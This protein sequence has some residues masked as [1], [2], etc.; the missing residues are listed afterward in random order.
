M[1]DGFV[2]RSF[3]MP[4]Q[5]IEPAGMWETV[6]ECWRR[7][8]DLANWCVHE[9]AKND[10]TRTPDMTKLPAMP[11]INGVKLKGLYGKASEFFGFTKEGSWWDGACVCA[12]TICRDVET[13]YKA[14]RLELI[15]HR[16]RA[17]RFYR[18]PY[19]WPIHSNRWVSARFDQN[20]RPCVE[21]ILP[22]RELAFADGGTGIRLRGGK[23]FARQMGLFRQVVSR[24]LPRL[25]CVLREHK[26]LGTSSRP[27]E[28]GGS[29][30]MLKMVAKLPVKE[31]KDG[32]VMTLFTDKEAFWV[33]SL[34]G[35]RED[36]QWTANYD[37]VRRMYDWLGV[38][39]ARRQRLSQDAKMES[40]CSSSKRRQ[41]QRSL[42]N[43]CEKQKRRMSSWLHEATAHV[44]GYCV[45]QG[46]SEVIYDSSQRFS[47]G[48]PWFRL[49]SMLSDKLKAEGIQ[50]HEAALNEDLVT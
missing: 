35:K 1:S 44:V 13:S 46:V 32:K 27:D 26:H 34:S 5:V 15:W 37:H 25:Q 4:V 21:V 14:D 2:V 17:L 47:D 50:L 31:K 7:G 8:T 6:R 10:I 48:F 22:G 29:R 36:K 43:A 20:G 30:L 16:K 45:R 11:P 3:E 33:A 18:Y 41:W 19:P 40:Q 9:L 23:E 38:H 49:N 28:P 24:D 42:D 39:N 12:S